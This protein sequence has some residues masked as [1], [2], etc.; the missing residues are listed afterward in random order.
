MAEVA[1]YRFLPWSRRGLA[2][3]V[4]G[5]DA[6]GALP[7]R[8]TVHTGVTVTGAGTTGIDL[9]LYGPGDI[10]GID[11][12]LIVRTDPRPG[13]TDVEPNYLPAIEFD[14]PDFA[15]AFTPAKPGAGDRLRPW[16]VL[17]CVDRAVVSPPQVSIRGGV[18][19][20]LPVLRLASSAVAT[21]LPDLR[22]SWAWAHT[23]V[24]TE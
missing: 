18:R 9:S 5:A 6:G 8:A 22:E 1:Q 2:A 24:A 23:Q 13:S 17:V 14:P 16:L 15:W 3:E 11:T 4:G 12:R 19:G 7:V 21:E 10:I 20:P